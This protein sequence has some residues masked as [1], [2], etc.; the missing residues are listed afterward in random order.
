MST[1]T[2]FSRPIPLAPLQPGSRIH[3]VGTS[4]ICYSST[5][6]DQLQAHRGCCNTCQGSEE[7]ER[8]RQRA[9][10]IYTA[11]EDHTAVEDPTADRGQTIGEHESAPEGQQ[12]PSKAVESPSWLGQVLESK[13]WGVFAWL[14]GFAVVIVTLYFTIIYYI[15]NGSKDFYN[16]CFQVNVRTKSP[17]QVSAPR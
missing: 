12:Q 13:I 15:W 5:L 4:S 2:N 10:E 17:A 7:H 3:H 8:A 11:S 14:L 1:T 9:D 6:Q 16:H